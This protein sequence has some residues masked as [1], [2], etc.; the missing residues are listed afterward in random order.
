MKDYED[1]YN[2]KLQNVAE[3]QA[4]IVSLSSK[5][6]DLADNRM[7]LVLE[8][9][10]IIRQ[11]IRFNYLNE[12]IITIFSLW[13]TV[14]V[15]TVINIFIGFVKFLWLVVAITFIYWFW[16]AKWTKITQLFL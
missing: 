14:V 7:N 4:T 6:K 12:H 1:L 3:K 16:L 5:L 8:S 11:L 15:S 9:S 13:V 10:P 2:I